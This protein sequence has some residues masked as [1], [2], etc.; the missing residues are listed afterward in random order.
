MTML[1]VILAIVTGLAYMSQNYSMKYSDNDQIKV[2]D[3]YLIILLVFLVLFAGLRTAYNDTQT[4]VMGFHNS[5]TFINFLSN[6]ENLEFFNNPLFYGFQALIRTFTNNVNVFF[7]ICAAIVNFLN[8]SFIK[9]QTNIEDF[10]FSMF[11][12]VALGTL[13]LSIAAQKQILAMSILTLAISAL[14]DEN[15]IKYYIVVF[16]AGLIHSYAW[17]F[18]FL[19]FMITKPWSIRTFILLGLTIIVM[20]V[21]QTTFTTLLEVADQIGKNVPIEEVFDGNRMNIFRVGVYLVVP[22]ITLIFKNTIN[23]NI[24]RK[25]S[26]FI[27]MSI[28]SLSFMMLGMMNGA[29]M[30]GRAGNYFEIGMI[31]SL[32][33]VVRQLFTKQSTT[34]VLATAAILFSCFY[35]YDNNDFSKQ[36]HRIGFNQFIHE[37]VGDEV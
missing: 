32:P 2:W 28:L 29:N 5:E 16:M 6:R 34:I 9:K 20:N 19:P 23:Q 21:F 11:L 14:I 8:I 27:Q 25:Y 33:W 13:M 26:I 18:L 7:I 17:L 4:Y 30:F 35:L 10:A 12:Y 3:P 36:Y 1:L 22:L 24:D 37:I 31:C 15:Y